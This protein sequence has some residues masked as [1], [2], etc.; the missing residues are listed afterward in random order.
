MNGQ[1]ICWI[2]AIVLFVIDGFMAFRTW[3]QHWALTAIG[4][5]F[6]TLGFLLPLV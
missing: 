5:A 1:V 4:L 6:L 2:I 3:A